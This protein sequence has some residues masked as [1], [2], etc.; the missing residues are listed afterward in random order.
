MHA[1]SVSNETKNERLRSA[2]TQME[3]RWGT[4]IVVPARITPS[5]VEGLS[6]TFPA[7]DQL[8]GTRGIPLHA[9]TVL[10]GAATSGKLTIAYKVLSQA[11]QS[12]P[13]HRHSVAVLDLGAS[14]DPDYI[15]RSGLDLDRLLI[16][17]PQTAKQALRAFLDLVR[18]RELRAILVDSLPEL[19]GDREAASAVEQMMPQVNL[20]LKS[21][22]CALLLLDDPQPAWLPPL[23]AS[24]S[25][26]VRHHASLH[27]EF[28]RQGW[29]EPAG[30]LTGYRVQARLLK[31]RSQRQGE[32]ASIS[33][34]FSQTVRARETW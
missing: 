1:A 19:M 33:I 34:T 13:E 20:A 4:G 2:I 9:M 14:T 17:R 7:L 3:H 16:A 25:R 15:A 6:T 32:S 10:A 31:S 27:L 18:S 21:A 22:D 11:Q 24:L 8:T 23:S 26:S 12:T 5:R 29:I 28:V 30:E